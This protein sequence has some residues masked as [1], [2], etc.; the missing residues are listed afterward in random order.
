MMFLKTLY[1]AL[2]VDDKGVQQEC[3]CREDTRSCQCNV[4]HPDFLGG[5]LG[6]F[7]ATVR[8]SLQSLIVCKAGAAAEV[9]EKEDD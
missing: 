2:L 4:H 5:K 3:S 7:D 8:H 9:A 1:H 6:Y